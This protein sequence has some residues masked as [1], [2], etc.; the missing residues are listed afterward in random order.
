MGGS[1]P[2][3]STKGL[4]VCGAEDGGGGGGPVDSQHMGIEAGL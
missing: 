1:N 3:L 4:I 2:S